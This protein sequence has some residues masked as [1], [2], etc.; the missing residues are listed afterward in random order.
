MQVTV[1]ASDGSS[2][3]TVA[4]KVGKDATHQPYGYVDPS[5]GAQ[6]PVVADTWKAI[7]HPATAGGDYTITA[8]CT[9]CANATTATLRNVTFGDMWYCS[10]QVRSTYL[11]LPRARC[12]STTRLHS[13][14]E[15][16]NARIKP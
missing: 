11:D 7:L 4:A 16:L 9:G 6:L 2:S 13:L 14:T 12:N 3:Y 5:T 1:S 15:L 8:T 10:G